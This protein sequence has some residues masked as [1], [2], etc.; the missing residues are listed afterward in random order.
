MKIAMIGQKRIPSR[1]GG[2]EVHVEEIAVRL[3]AKG[4]DVT[5]YN[6]K[7]KG[8]PPLHMYQGVRIVSVPGVG[9]KGAQAAVCSFLATA[10]A[11]FGHYDV[12]HYHAEGPSAMLWIPRLF[13]V[14]TVATIHGLD[15]RRTKWGRFAVWF[16]KHGEKTA[17]RYADEVAVLSR[18]AQKYFRETYGRE[19]R[20]I[21]NGVNVPAIRDACRIKDRYGLEK[22][23]YLL[24]VARI[25]P[26]KGLHGLLR[27]FSRISTDKKLVVAGAGCRSDAYC[28]GV[29]AVARG[30]GRVV[31]TGF[32]QG[33]ELDE[34][35]SNAFLYIL[36]SEVEGMPLSLLE[37]MSYG[38]P[39]LASDIPE[40]REVLEGH[41]FFFRKGDAADLTVKLAALLRDAGIKEIGR[42][43][44]RHVLKTYGWDRAVG[45]LEQCYLAA[46]RHEKA[47]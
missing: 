30:D 43:A 33:V 10:L 18:S 40:N 5:V 2:V 39:C 8:F 47:G 12:I 46:A 20:L 41:G 4:H 28:R 17:A 22:D 11:L 38:C 45:Q 42:E 13:G 23:G 37:A 44:R 27:A 24:F 9:R 31:L 25:V 15:W 34:L 19:T 21:P 3:A 29:E 32:V 36:P 35:Y 6:R 16:L 1:E 26:E 7:K 14:G